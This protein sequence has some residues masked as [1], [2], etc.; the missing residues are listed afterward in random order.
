MTSGRRHLWARD[1]DVSLNGAYAIGPWLFVE[2]Q[3]AYHKYDLNPND[4]PGPG[5][6]PTKYGATEFDVGFALTF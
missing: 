4:A 6:Q 5:L 1:L 2:D 3:V